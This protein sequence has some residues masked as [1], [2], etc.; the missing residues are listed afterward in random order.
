[1]R[2]MS[3][4]TKGGKLEERKGEEFISKAKRMRRTRRR[5]EDRRGEGMRKGVERKDEKTEGANC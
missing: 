2:G 4:Q 5:E 1:M 3:K